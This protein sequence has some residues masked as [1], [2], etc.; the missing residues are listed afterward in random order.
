MNRLKYAT[1]YVI[2]TEEQLDCVHFSDESKFNLFGCDGR[3]FDR[4]SPK[5]R[6]LPLCSKSRYKFGGVSVMVFGMIQVLV[7]DF[8]SGY[9]VKLTQLYTK[10]YWRN[11]L[12]LIWELQLINQRY[13]RKLT[14]HITQR[15]LLWIFFFWWGCY[16]YEVASSKPRHESFWE[17]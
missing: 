13:L 4:H 14:P 17:C 2:W 5:E 7:Q 10:R 16:C 6:Y 15:S 11:V 8:L 1:E 9:T 12:Y 3:R